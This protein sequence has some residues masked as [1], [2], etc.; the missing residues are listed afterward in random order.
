[1]PVMRLDVWIETGRVLELHTPSLVDLRGQVLEELTDNSCRML[2][3]VDRAIV[4]HDTLVRAPTFSS[5]RT[6]HLVFQLFDERA[7]YFRDVHT[8]GGHLDGVD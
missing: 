2:V 1:M 8:T 7:V 5:S 3:R 6:T 4:E